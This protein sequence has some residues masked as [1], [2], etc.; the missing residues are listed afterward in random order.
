M[1]RL[2][3]TTGLLAAAL[4][5]TPQS[6]SAQGNQPVGGGGGQQQPNLS[7]PRSGGSQRVR[8]GGES[9]GAGQGRARHGA[10]RPAGRRRRRSAGPQSVPSAT[11]ADR[12]HRLASRTLL[13]PTLTERGGGGAILRQRGSHAN[14]DCFI[15]RHG[16]GIARGADDR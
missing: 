10:Q 2:I 9:V 14:H 3:L 12:A 5:A 11:V 13:S 8:P 6:A 1:R 16:G 15:R 7:E 4:M